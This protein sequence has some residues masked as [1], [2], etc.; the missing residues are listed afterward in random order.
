MVQPEQDD[1]DPR[2][3]D[4]LLTE[5]A[6]MSSRWHLFCKFLRQ[7]LV[8]VLPYR[9]NSHLS[10]VATLSF[11][12]TLVIP[13]PERKETRTFILTQKPYAVF[14]SPGPTSYLWSF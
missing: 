4:K 13:T 3:I 12:T 6:S 7:T 1:V 5:I 14:K 8:G 11:R 10:S 2:E 9:L